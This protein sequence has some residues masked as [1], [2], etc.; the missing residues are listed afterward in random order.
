MSSLIRRGYEALPTDEFSEKLI[1]QGAGPLLPAPRS[2]GRMTQYKS[3]MRRRRTR[4]LAAKSVI[5]AAIA[6]FMS[7]LTYSPLERSWTAVGSS[8]FDWYRTCSQ[9]GSKLLGI[10]TIAF[11]I[12]ISFGN[13]GVC[14]KYNKSFAVECR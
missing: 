7:F 4:R 12:F 9:R 3:G 2:M 1:G 10:A 8:L 14:C 6:M 11:T 5:T 13:A